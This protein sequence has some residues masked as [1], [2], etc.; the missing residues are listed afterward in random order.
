MSWVYPAPLRR[1][2]FD[3]RGQRL[4]LVAAR[5]VLEADRSPFLTP[6][7]RLSDSE[8]QDAPHPSYLQMW[9]STPSR[10]PA[11]VYKRG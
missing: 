11:S 7:S 9:R 8:R 5:R 2:R 6:V 3:L 4:D 10:G 1:E